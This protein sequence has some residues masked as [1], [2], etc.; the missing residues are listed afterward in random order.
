[1]V[2]ETVDL[3]NSEFMA[4]LSA[5]LYAGPVKVIFYKVD[6]TLREMLCTLNPQMLPEA[7]E[8]TGKRTPN[9]NVMPVWDLGKGAWRSFRKDS[10]QTFFHVKD[11]P[12]TTGREKMQL[13]D[14]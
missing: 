5:Y 1:M 2:E 10:V 7:P 11:D 12:P 6:G 3:S 8:G 4:K 14:M 9:P 13:E